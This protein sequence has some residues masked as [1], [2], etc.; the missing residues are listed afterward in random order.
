MVVLLITQWLFKNSEAEDIVSDYYKQH[1]AGSWKRNKKMLAEKRVMQWRDH[2]KQKNAVGHTVQET[3]SIGCIGIENKI[4][5][6]S[7]VGK[8]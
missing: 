8:S 6:E 4:S 7:V 5:L 1:F 2:I 3:K